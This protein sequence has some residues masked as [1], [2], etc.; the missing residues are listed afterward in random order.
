[1]ADLSKLKQ[2]RGTLGVPPPIE[3][4]SSNLSAPEIAPVAPSEPPPHKPQAVGRG[5]GQK[6]I[7]GRS[8]RKSGRTV[9]FAT[10]VS[11]E[12]EELLHKIA[13]RDGL[14]L[15]E[16]LEK[17]VSAYEATRKEREAR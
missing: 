5:G 10:R 9:P 11:E 17:G 13:K 15:V 16:V 3:E 6:R 14:L 8:L 1:M 12:F 2:R 4:A 7:D